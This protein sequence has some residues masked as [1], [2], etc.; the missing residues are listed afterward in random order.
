VAYILL[1]AAGFLALLL[2]DWADSR[3]LKKVKPPVMIGAW[4]LFLFA[5]VTV[6]ASPDRFSVSIGLRIAGGFF[7]LVFFSLFIYSLLLEIPFSQT[8]VGKE[9]ERRVVATGTYALVRH[10]GVIWF[11][12]FHLSFVLVVGSRLL[13]IAVPFWTGMNIVLVTI[14]D[15]VFFLKTFGD[16][17]RQYQQNVPFLVP[18][19]GSIR[20]CIATFQFPFLKG[21]R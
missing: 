1:G 12:L 5:F 18:T 10:P 14:E 7:S 19:P 16:S 9:G 17:Y 8:Y 2:F 4:G 15:K 3:G 20:Q 6:V 21:K 13:L 11:L